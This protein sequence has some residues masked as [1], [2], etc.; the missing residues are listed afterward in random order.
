[1]CSSVQ[2]EHSLFG[3]VISA[4]TLGRSASITP[5][6]PG[7]IVTDHSHPMTTSPSG[8]GLEQHTTL[9]PTNSLQCPRSVKSPIPQNSIN[10]RDLFPHAAK[11][12]SPPTSNTDRCNSNHYPSTVS[13]LCPAGPQH[14]QPMQS[15]RIKLQQLSPVSSTEESCNASHERFV[16]CLS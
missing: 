11:S 14:H 4:L 15:P 3:T 7:T 9:S 1:M 6:R 12:V 10:V 2:R 16:E 13:R 5:S 8:G